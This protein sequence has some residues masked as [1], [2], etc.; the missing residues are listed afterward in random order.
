M[1]CA[2]VTSGRRLLILCYQVQTNAEEKSRSVA[3]SRPGRTAVNEQ[4]PV[5]DKNQDDATTDHY[6]REIDRLAEVVRSRSR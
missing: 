3:G 2:G 1:T 5:H 4:H 6:E